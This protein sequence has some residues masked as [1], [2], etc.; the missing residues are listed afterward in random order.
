MRAKWCWRVKLHNSIIF[1][2]DLIQRSKM[3]LQEENC[4]GRMSP[5]FT[6]T[7]SFI[8][9]FSVKYL[10]MLLVSYILCLFLLGI[11]ERLLWLCSQ[12]HHCWCKSPLL[13]RK[14]HLKGASCALL[15]DQLFSCLQISDQNFFPPFL[16][17][18]SYILCCHQWK[19]NLYN[20]LLKYSEIL[21]FSIIMPNCNGLPGTFYN[22]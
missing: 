10:E 6:R 20:E 4:C 16:L 9:M 18:F 17:T 3:S 1:Y 19:N 21:N 22:L 5:V 7:C 14:C 13:T 15:T 12:S 11:Q 2:G 8:E